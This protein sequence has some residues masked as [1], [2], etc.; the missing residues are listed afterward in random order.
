MVQGRPLDQPCGPLTKDPAGVHQLGS[1]QAARAP[2][3]ASIFTNAAS[4]RVGA[5]GGQG[6]LLASQEADGNDTP[7]TCRCRGQPESA[8]MFI[9]SLRLLYDQAVSMEA[10]GMHSDCSPAQLADWQPGES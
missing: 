6:L 8:T 10:Q 4:E 1:Q 7:C 9:T 3:E 5:I 2:Q